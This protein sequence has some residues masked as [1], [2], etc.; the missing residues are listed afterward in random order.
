LGG[1]GC[2][3]W[4]GLFTVFLLVLG[5]AAAR[6]AGE[7]HLSWSDCGTGSLAVRNLDFS[8]DRNSDTLDLHIGFVPPQTT[9]ADVIG[10]EVVIDIQI[11]QDTLVSWWQLDLFDGCRSG[12]LRVDA[13]VDP[14]GCAEPWGDIATAE[15][16]D[17]VPG[18]PRGGAQARIKVVS[19]VPVSR[20]RT[21]SRDTLYAA[22]RLRIATTRT[23]G[24][25]L[26]PGCNI[27]VCLV[28]NSVLI[29]RLP[30]APGG[31]LFVDT[32]GAGSANRVTYQGGA[33]ADCALV[34][35]RPTSWGAIKSLYRP[36]PRP[37]TR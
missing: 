19:G 17:Y 33:G 28:L 3:W 31:D 6:A 35:T 24:P 1:S 22:A 30:G 8:C 36:N 2:S 5:P 23:T 21:L 4:A 9:G 12:A 37:G 11:A 20:A 18:E 15:V 26:C 32:P 34:P 7:L 16:Q 25:D 10:V 14:G 29:R 27:P 13:G